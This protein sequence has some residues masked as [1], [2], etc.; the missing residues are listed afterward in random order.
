MLSL[1]NLTIRLEGV[2]L[3]RGLDLALV[4]GETLGLVGESG[5]GKSLTALAI[6][7]LL[8]RE[9]Q[10]SGRILFEGQDL[11]ALDQADMDLWR[12]RR[13]GM[14]FQEPMT[15]LNPVMRIGEQIAEGIVLHGLA[16]RHDAMREA[17]QLL[18]RVRLDDPERRLRAYPHE[19]SGGQ[20]Q[21]VLI[22]MAI[23]CKPDLLIADEPTSA[24]DVTVQAQIL[25]LLRDL[26]RETG[27]AMLFISHDLG[28]IRRV[29][30]QLAVLYAGMW[31]EQGPV[32]NV[33]RAPRH[34]YTQGLIGALPMGR[35]RLTPI[36][37]QVPP[38]R[39]RAPGCSFYGRCIAGDARCQREVPPVVSGSS[40]LRCFYPDER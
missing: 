16:S 3:L 19:L 25:D 32:A 30:D 22:A 24:L 10:V 17:E 35:K 13:M 9:M 20:R 11:L 28:V 38:P 21:R 5:S 7:G 1:E 37:G 18:S 34:R 15:A 36:A 2:E 8:P 12:G 23:A 33:L 31:V 27:M 40:T 4:R 14:V 39:D 26:Q 29:A 6:M